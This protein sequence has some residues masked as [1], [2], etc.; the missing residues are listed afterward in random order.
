MN[1]ILS[2]SK[3]EINE[4]LSVVEILSREKE[5]DEIDIDLDI[6]KSNILFIIIIIIIIYFGIII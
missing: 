1:R 3:L 6:E 2:D 5:N 4:K